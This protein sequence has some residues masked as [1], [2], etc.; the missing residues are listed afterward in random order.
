MPPIHTPTVYASLTCE[1]TLEGIIENTH[2]PSWKHHVAILP[3]L[4][5]YL[6]F[7]Y[8][9]ICY[10]SQMHGEYSKTLG[11]NCFWLKPQKLTKGTSKWFSWKRYLDLPYLLLPFFTSEDLVARFSFLMLISIAI[12]NTKYIWYI[13]TTTYLSTRCAPLHQFHPYICYTLSATF[14]I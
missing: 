1:R 13:F 3:R 6:I 7:Q 10:I 2:S 9:K 11:Q 12:R 8:P 14:N 5:G 4:A